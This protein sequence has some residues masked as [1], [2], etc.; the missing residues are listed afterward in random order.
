MEWI[1]QQLEARGMNRRMLAD[2]IGLTEV[3]L[4][5]VMGGSRRLTADEA[6]AIR[7]FFGYRLPDDPPVTDLDKIQDYLSQL[8]A[9]QRRAVVLYL[10]ALSGG[11][12]ERHRAS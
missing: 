1:N 4:S 2:A 5:K 10:E 3:Q 11:E 8:G 7:R 9:P 6:D 12:Q